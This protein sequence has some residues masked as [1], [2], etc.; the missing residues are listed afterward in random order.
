MKLS[1]ITIALVVVALWGFTFSVT[2]LALETFT[3]SEL[4]F[5]RFALAAAPMVFLKDRKSTRLNSSH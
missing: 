2:K 3:A 1:D 5:L 4:T